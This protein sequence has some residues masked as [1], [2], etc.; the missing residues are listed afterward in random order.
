[1]KR[2]VFRASY[3]PADY[4][5]VARTLEVNAG[6]VNRTARET[7]IP[8]TTVRR[9][10]ERAPDPRPRVD[11]RKILRKLRATRGNVA[12]TSRALGVS[13][14]RVTRL[15]DETVSGFGERRPPK[16]ASG[17]RRGQRARVLRELRANG[18]NI[19]ATVR[20]TGI[21]EATVRR[22]AAEQRS[23]RDTVDAST[24]YASTRRDEQTGC[25]V[26]AGQINPSGYGVT[27]LGGKPRLAHRVSYE[28]R[29]PGALE[30]RQPLHHVCR[31]TSCVETAHL[32]P[33]AAAGDRGHN[34]L[35]RLEDRFIAAVEA[36]DL[37]R[38]LAL[39]AANGFE[40]MP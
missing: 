28:L 1:M 22:W 18:Q 6:N 21:P 31:N 9:W 25:L 4:Q 34:A 12:A 13:R 39:V 11:N 8:A 40:L 23:V 20:A 5:L 36:G 17:S 15:R 3:V 30:P 37:E 16:R 2:A 27:S 26:W 35:H 10:K 38:E 32:L 33:V 19:K 7:G 14:E 24:F 29:Y